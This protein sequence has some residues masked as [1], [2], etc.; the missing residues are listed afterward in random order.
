MMNYDVKIIVNLVFCVTPIPL[1]S[2]I[3]FRVVCLCVR[4][5]QTDFLPDRDCIDQVFPVELI[6][7]HEQAIFDS[8][9]RAILWPRLS[10]N[11]MA[12]KL[13]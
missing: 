10:Q 1:V 11:E 6:S 9:H 5:I 3:F 2:V 8:V 4:G 12:G 7:L 13:T